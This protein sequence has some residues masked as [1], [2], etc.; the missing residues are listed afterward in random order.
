MQTKVDASDLVQ[1]TLLDTHRDFDHFAGQT[2]GEW[3]ARLRQILAHN[4]G[5]AIRHF[6]T[7]EKR[8]AKREVSLSG[9]G[10]DDSAGFAWEPPAP[11]ASPS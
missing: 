6:G 7:A 3:L 8:A 2:E 11:G 10:P 4:T 1:L 5:D 9:A